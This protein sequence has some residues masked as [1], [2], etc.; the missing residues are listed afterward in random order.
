MTI[1]LFV[2]GAV[3]YRQPLI[4]VLLLLMIILVPVSVFITLMCAERL[5]PD[6]CMDKT[7]EISVTQPVNLS[8]KLS[9]PTII[10][11]L[12]CRVDFSLGNS[13]MGSFE[14]EVVMPAEARRVKEVRIPI[15]TSMPGMIRVVF[16]S[17]SVTDF[18]HICTF[19]YPYEKIIEL[20]VMPADRQLPPLRFTKVSIPSDEAVST[21]DG[22]LTTD[23]KEVREYRNGDRLRDIH[24]KISARK[25]EIMVKEYDRTKDLYYVVLPEFEYDFLKDDIEVFYACGKELLKRKETFRVAL[26]GDTGDYIELQKVA[27]PEE[28]D[29]VLY[30]IYDVYSGLKSGVSS[31]VYDIFCRQYPDMPGVIRV[32]MGNIIMPDIIEEY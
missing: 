28:L 26:A 22:D 2:L 4:A 12:N 18:L 6:A 21:G 11:L 24:W 29:T 1:L 19:T 8:I 31:Q 14:N 5:D 3:F 17:L 20:P 23:I 25:D 13:L 15:E 7:G 16:S 27:S 9:N 32:H 30:R 10:P